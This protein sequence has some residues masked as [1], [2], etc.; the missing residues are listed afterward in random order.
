MQIALAF[1][2]EIEQAVLRQVREHVVEEADAGRNLGTARAVQVD[3]EVDLGFGGFALE[4]GS[5]RGM[6]FER[7]VGSH[8]KRV[9]SVLNSLRK[10]SISASVPTD[11]R[12]PSP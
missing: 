5:V 2:S 12:R 8:A 10:M 6:A 9:G 1:D 3:R 7:P 4:R 11:T